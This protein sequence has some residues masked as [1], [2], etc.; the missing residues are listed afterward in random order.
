MAPKVFVTGGTGFI[1]GSVLHTIATAHPEYDITV[2]LRRIP[3]AFEITY[4]SITILRGDYDSFDTLA[5]A[6]EQAD[7]VIHNGDSDHEASLNAIL[8]GLLKRQTPGY[9]L[10]LSGTGIVSDWTTT[11]LS[12]LGTL[13][14]KIWSDISSI[15][16]IKSLPARALHRNT[17]RILHATAAKHG[18]RVHIAIMC[19]PDIYGKGKGLGKTQSAFVPL[20]VREIR[21]LGGRVFYYGDGTNTRSWVHVDDLMRVYLRVVEAAAAGQADECF[22]SNGYFFAG[23]QEHSHLDVARVTGRILFEKGVVSDPEPRRIG[24][25]ELDAMVQI[26]GY[27]SL[28]RYLFAGNS[29]TRAE[30]AE[31]LFGYRG[32]ARGLLDCLEADVGD[33]L[34]GC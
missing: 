21:K 20:Y 2:L 15:N 29:R 25:E 17:E 18:D 26:P 13:N 32:E 19:P 10:H 3:E 11:N 22:G 4:P 5:S 30:R 14:P 9:L 16:E 24:L 8:A 23:T 1:G 34:E 7:I 27:G 31:G 12:Q 28:A 33:V 6:A